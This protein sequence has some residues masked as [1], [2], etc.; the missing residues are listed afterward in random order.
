AAA[1]RRSRP[2]IPTVE[3]PRRLRLANTALSSS[4]SLAV[5]PGFVQQFHRPL[6]GQLFQYARHRGCAVVRCFYYGCADYWRMTTGRPGGCE[7]DRVELP[8]AQFAQPRVEVAAQRFND[9]IRPP[10]QQLA[11]PPQ[12]AGADARVRRQVRQSL[13]LR[14][15]EHIARIRSRRHRGK[16]QLL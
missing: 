6:A 15:N 12:A 7:D 1:W 4:R 5:T 16:D 9:Y 13:R 3:L 2:T 11:P 10:R 8:F 14:T